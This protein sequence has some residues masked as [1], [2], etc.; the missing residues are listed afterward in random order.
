MNNEQR[1]AL[2]TRPHGCA[3]G[4][5]FIEVYD[6]TGGPLFGAYWP[7]QDATRFC[8]ES[9]ARIVTDIRKK[10]AK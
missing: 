9:G 7:S 4:Q 3:D 6:C 10:E 5:V 1:I 2:I 8:E